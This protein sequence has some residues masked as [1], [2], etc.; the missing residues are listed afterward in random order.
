MLEL[1]P[2]V[3]PEISEKTMSLFEDTFSGY[4]NVIKVFL[5]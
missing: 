1:P 3:D 4:M 2:L 5:V